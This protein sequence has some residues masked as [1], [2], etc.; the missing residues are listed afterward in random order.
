M[1]DKQA[2]AKLKKLLGP[3]YMARIN[4]RALVGEAREAAQEQ[5]RGAIEARNAARAA[6][7]ARFDELMKDPEYRRLKAVCIAAE[8][9]CERK[10]GEARSRRITVG[11]DSG[12]AFHVKAEGD[13]WDDVISALEKETA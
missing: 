7:Q 5:A 1:N 10:L 3:K 9:V 6:Q 2:I 13:N 12:F 11:L 8:T 4:D